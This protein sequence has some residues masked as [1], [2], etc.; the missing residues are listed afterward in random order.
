MSFQRHTFRH[1]QVHPSKV[2]PLNRKYALKSVHLQCRETNNGVNVL[3]SPLSLYFQ[4]LNVH[5]RA[6]RTDQ[7]RVS[8]VSLGL[9]PND[10]VLSVSRGS[11]G[12]THLAARITVFV[13]QGGNL[14]VSLPVPL[15]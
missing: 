10:R 7:C 5:V 4:H 1:P 2:Q 11:L 9:L 6:L 14:P 3:M 15:S 13:L 12:P 8:W